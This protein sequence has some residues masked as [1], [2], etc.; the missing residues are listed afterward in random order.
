VGRWKFGW[1]QPGQGFC[2][3]RP[4][5]DTAFLFVFAAAGLVVAV[6]FGLGILG[7]VIFLVA[8][9]APP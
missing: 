6:D 8:A 4:R 1:G 7:S 2:V 9:R 5:F 3:W